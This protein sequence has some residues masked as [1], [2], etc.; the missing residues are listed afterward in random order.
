MVGIVLV[1]HSKKL[2]EGVAELAIAMGGPD[3]PLRA[4]GGLDL[5]G[6]PLGTDASRVLEAIQAVYSE[7]GVL[8]LMDL[9]SAVLSAEMA[10]EMLAEEQRSK[11]ILSTAPLVEG[12]VAAAVQARLGSP[13]ERVISEAQEA[14]AA[15]AKQLAPNDTLNQQSGTESHGIAS[16]ETSLTVD[17][18][19]DSRTGLH[20][21]PAA[22][23]VQ[24]ANRF[25][26]A[27]IT[28]RNTTRGRGPV[29]AKSINSVTGLGVEQG[30]RIQL[31]AAGTDAQ[32]ALDAL[33]SLIDD[34][35][36][37]ELS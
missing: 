22:R 10:L 19:V 4:V 7:D 12:A 27:E 8:V 25:P 35:F 36:G 1:S 31:S 14:L 20:A 26:E 28:V 5:P 33:C 18:I 32:H 23:F 29:S 17:R 21:R 30:D 6:Y 13:I 16:P 3:L 2:A 34:N 11:V 9:G 15:K 37:D 24:L